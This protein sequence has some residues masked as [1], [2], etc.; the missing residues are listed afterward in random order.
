MTT[1]SSKLTTPCR[2]AG[3]SIAG[4]A[5]VEWKQR[6]SFF[7]VS[8]KAAISNSSEVLLSGVQIPAMDFDLAEESQGKGPGRKSKNITKLKNRRVTR[9]WNPPSSKNDKVTLHK[10]ASS[11]KDV[12]NDSDLEVWYEKVLIRMS[13]VALESSPFFNT[14]CAKLPEK[15]SNPYFKNIKNYELIL[16]VTDFLMSLFFVK[17]V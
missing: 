15:T 3:K 1:L 7:L 16:E 12:K 9:K 4:N 6:R 17:V 14:L 11:L 13:V 10:L 8:I 2:Y 5:V